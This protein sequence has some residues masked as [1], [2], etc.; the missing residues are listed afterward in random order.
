MKRRSL[1][2]RLYLMYLI[3]LLPLL[4][5]GC[6]KNGVEVYMKGF[7]GLYGLAKPLLLLSCSVLGAMIGGILREWKNVKKFNF[8]LL[9]KIKGDVVEAVLVVAILPID[10][11]PL[12][13]LGIT[14][15]FGLFLG[16]VKINKVA[17]LYIV[18]E[19][20]NVLWGLNNFKNAYEI[21]TVLNYNGLDLFFGSGTG[22]IFST[23]V[24][25]ILMGYL[26]LSYNK[27]YK[28]EM[29]LASVATFLLL[30]SIPKMI[31]GQYTEILPYIFGYNV[32]FVLVFVAPNLYSSSYTLK[33]QIVSGI[34]I[35]ILCFAI[36]FM[37]S[38]TA[39]VLAVL[40]ASGLKGILD[41]MFVIK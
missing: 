41:R 34:L 7:V 11:N 24:F 29:V 39:A 30:G 36:S 35:G 2:T 15:A 26:F 31:G 13:I 25:L 3:A 23:N 1:N 38:Y 10:S 37:T 6:Y 17:L 21:N 33:G 16:K 9:D 18:I 12:T 14:M 32:L 19:G 8:S 22:G 20:L 28:K 27:L 40:I 5:F 4:I